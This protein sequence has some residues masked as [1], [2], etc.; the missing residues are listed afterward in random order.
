MHKEWSQD[1]HKKFCEY[2]PTWGIL[3]N[4]Y[5]ILWVFFKVALH[6]DSKMIVTYYIILQLRWIFICEQFLRTS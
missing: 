4:S 1:Y 5:E 3:N 6:P 2:L